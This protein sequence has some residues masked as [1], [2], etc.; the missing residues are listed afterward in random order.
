MTDTATGSDAMTDSADLAPPTTALDPFNPPSQAVRHELMA[1]M[2][3]TC[4]V[5]SFSEGRWYAATHE[6]VLQ[7]LKEV[8]KF[9]GSFIDTSKLPEDEVPV[10]AIPEPQHGK[11]RRVI[12]GVLAPHRTMHADTFV[13]ELANS[14]L[15]EALANSTKAKAPE[16]STAL[17][18][19]SQPNATGESTAEKDGSV[20]EQPTS[21]TFDLVRDY[22]DPIPST[23]IAHVLGVPTEDFDRFRRWSDELLENMNTQLAGEPLTLSQTHPEFAAYIQHHIDIRRAAPE[24]P[25]DLIG[26]FINADIDGQPLSDAMIR[27]QAI[28]LII[29]GNETT[30]NWL[31]NFFA[32]LAQSPDLYTEVRAQPDIREQFMEESLRRD[33]PVQIVARAAMEDTVIEKQHIPEGDQVVFGIA[34]A[35][36]DEK[37]FQNPA[38][39]NH[40]RPDLKKHLAFGAGPHICPGA[41]L[42]RLEAR[43][44]LEVFCEKVASFTVAP[45]YEFQYN[46]VFWALGL[47]SLPVYA[48]PAAATPAVASPA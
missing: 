27:T 16:A 44:A 17:A 23:V 41:T 20:A 12:N 19:G 34:S 28:N 10:S 40:A 38:E 39:F 3:E 42:A 32:T 45:D 7:G 36:R 4:P 33:C 2:R 11:I 8:D 1:E 14:L 18:K 30:R 47:R 26:R 31:G 29:A 6:G 43:I 48:V 21:T 37:V 5:A 24:P 9:V 35:N 46:P 25:D 15:D 13:Y 22:T